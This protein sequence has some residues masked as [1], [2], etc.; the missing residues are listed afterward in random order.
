MEDFLSRHNQKV[1]CFQAHINKFRIA[2]KGY[3]Q[4]D[5]EPEWIRTAEKHYARGV[6]Y[7]EIVGLYDT[8][9]FGKG[10]TGF[11][12]TDDYLYWKRSISKGIIRLSDIV[13]ITYYDETKKKSEDRGIIFYMK[14]GSSVC[15]DG[16]CNLK[17]K[18]FIKFMNEYLSI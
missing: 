14:D 8:S 6:D 2:F 17:C 4:K 10:K 5:I 3:V 15:W 9:S 16:F 11:L 1:I 7:S 12:F 13:N 18:A